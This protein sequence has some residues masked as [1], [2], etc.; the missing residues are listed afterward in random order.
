MSEIKASVYHTDDQH[1][2]FNLY[3][4]YPITLERGSGSKV[5]D[6]NGREYIDALAGIAVNNIG[7]CHPRLVAAI[8]DQAGK[9]MHISNFYSSVPQVELAKKLTQLS[10]L[11]RAF[12]TNSGVEAMEGAMKLARKY[13]HNHG[14]SGNILTMDGCFHGRSLAAISAGK[15][16]YQEGF[17]PMMP[18]FKNIP[19][20]DFEAVKAHSDDQT[21]AIIIETVQGEGGIRP[22]SA[23]FIKNVLQFCTDQN[24]LL[25]L[26]EVQCG[27]GRTGKFYAYQHFDILPD[28]VCS[29]KGLGGGFPIGAVL[30]KE[31]VA[32]ALEYGQHGTTFGGNPLATRAAI[33][34]LDIMEDERIV[35]LA[36]ISGKW[37]MEQLENWAKT[38]RSVTEIRGLGLMVGVELNFPGAGVVERMMHKGVLSNCAS[39]NIIR[40]VPPLNITRAELGKV[41]EALAE[42][43]S[44]EKEIQAESNPS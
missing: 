1:V 11:D 21:I 29:A 40:L 35:E 25:I 2:H 27:V 23:D 18:G 44:E 14:K 28:I 22:V 12:F 8:S 7:H 30:A 19:F 5:W 41:L 42:S 20:N 37:L 15:K 3:K 17:E 39:G 6:T 33:E 24:I 10:G 9:L 26:D 13:G 43:V 32:L 36:G 4:R 16:K 38:E 31:E 34:V